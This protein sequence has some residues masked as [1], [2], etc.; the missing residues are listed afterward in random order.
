MATTEKTDAPDVKEIRDEYDDFTAQWQEIRAEGSKDMA[1]VAGD[2]WDPKDRRDRE[3]AGRP[4]LSLD[5]LGQYVNQLNNDVR[6][7]KRGIRVTP[8]AAGATDKTAEYRQNRIRQIEYKSNAQA[9][10]TTMFEN[11][12]QRSYGYLRIVTEYADFRSYD[13]EPRI[14]ACPNPDLVTPD[15]YGLSTDG[16]DWK[17]LFFAEQWKVS[18]FKR[19]Y[20]TKVAISDFGAEHATQAPNWIKGDRVLVAERWKVDTKPRQLL[21]FAV[22]PAQAPGPTLGVTRQGTPQTVGAFAD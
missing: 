17:R 9:A 2:P 11:A 18:D 14:K 5:E 10:Y 13:Q 8:E 22:P 7:K 16:A 4:V 19:K 15:P 1:C 21:L 20:G 3:A 6:Q 12:V